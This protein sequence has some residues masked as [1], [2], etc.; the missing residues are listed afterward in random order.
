M[1]V[2]ALTRN[3]EKPQVGVIIFKFKNVH[4]EKFSIMIL[5]ETSVLPSSNA[6]TYVSHDDVDT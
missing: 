5:M 6:L 4:A 3:E 1:T 2:S